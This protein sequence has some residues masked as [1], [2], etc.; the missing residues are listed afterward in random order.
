MEIILGS[1]DQENLRGLKKEKDQLNKYINTLRIKPSV[2][3]AYIHYQYEKSKVEMLTYFNKHYLFNTNLHGCARSICCCC[4][5]DPEP[6]YLFKGQK[7]FVKNDKVPEPEDIN[8]DSVEVGVC[9]KIC[10]VLVAILVIL[11]FLGISCTIIGL[12]SI[13]I[14]ANSI[15]CTSVVFPTSVAEA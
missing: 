8:W 4:V 14:S 6:K 13:Y 15:D 9:G 2:T 1:G 10:R 12:C 11:I 5:D 3:S 7:L